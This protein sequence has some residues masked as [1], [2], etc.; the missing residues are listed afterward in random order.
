MILLH[1]LENN[2][3]AIMNP[4]EGVSAEDMIA[5]VPTGSK[6][7]LITNWGS[8]STQDLDDFQVALRVNY[9]PAVTENYFSWDIDAA[10][11]ITKERL[12]NE[13]IPLF[14]ANDIALRD[15]ILANNAGDI[16]TFTTERDRLRDAPLLADSATTL[17]ELRNITL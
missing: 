11:E 7:R 17:E 13:R 4:A 2:R 12:R 15:A 1:E 6:Y 14:E 8:I 9:N 5:E 3:V 10:K 16:A